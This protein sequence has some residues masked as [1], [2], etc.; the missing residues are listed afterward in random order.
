M[1]DCVKFA[2]FVIWDC[3]CNLQTRGYS[4]LKYTQLLMLEVEGI[5]FK[6]WQDKK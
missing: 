5:C 1:F 2:E 6:K 4:N 3:F